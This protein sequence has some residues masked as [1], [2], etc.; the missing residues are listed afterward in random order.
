MRSAYHACNAY[1]TINKIQYNNTIHLYIVA[2]PHSFFFLDPILYLYH[3]PPFV[4]VF[5]PKH[6][7]PFPFSISI[8]PNPNPPPHTPTHALT[9]LP[10]EEPRKNVTE[11]SEP[12]FFLNFILVS[13]YDSTRGREDFQALFL[14]TT[15]SPLR[16]P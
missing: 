13:F 5:F 6:S 3:L 7:L 16:L 9:I 14:F 10:S 8:C 2:V 1:D 12:L 4:S 15:P 11:L